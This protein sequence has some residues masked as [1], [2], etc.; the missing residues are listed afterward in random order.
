MRQLD[1]CH[2]ALLPDESRDARQHLDV[3]VPPDSQIRR[4]NAPKGFDGSGLGKHQPGAANRS[5]TQVY[6]MPVVG[7]TIFA[8]IL[9]H[10]RNGDAVTESDAADRERRE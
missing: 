6:Q 10:R 1:A 2:G 5:A 8:G 7:K 4:R 3:L 9:A